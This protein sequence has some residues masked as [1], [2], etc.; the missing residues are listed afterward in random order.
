[1]SRWERQ[2]LAFVG[3]DIHKQ[4]HSAAVL[5]CYGQPLSTLAVANRPA[6]FAGFL[7]Q[8]QQLAPGK[9]LIFG[10]E[11]T[12]TWGRGLATYLMEQGHFDLTAIGGL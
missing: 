12:T 8:V 4:H 7:A 9:H 2:T 5:D 6:A 3:I 11:N 10:L 1:M